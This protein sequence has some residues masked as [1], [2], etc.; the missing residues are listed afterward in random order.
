MSLSNNT[1]TIRSDVYKCLSSNGIKIRKDCIY[2]DGSSVKLF[3][4]AL[5]DDSPS[6][7]FSMRLSDKFIVCDDDNTIKFDMIP[8]KGDIEVPKL[9]NE[10]LEEI[11]ENY[12]KYLLE[13]GEI[14][15]EEMQEALA[16]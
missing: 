8:F 16:D 15:E 6:R 12:Y 13:I 9:S 5:T 11:R 14:T 3:I 2:I 7:Q 10:E 1:D 4:K